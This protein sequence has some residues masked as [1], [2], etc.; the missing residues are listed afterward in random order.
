MTPLPPKLPERL[1][2]DAHVDTM[3]AYNICLRVES[4]LQQAVNN[5]ENIGN[6][7]IYIRILGYLIHFVPTDLGLRVVVAEILS[8]KSDRA[9]L[10]VGKMYFNHYIRACAF[11]NL[12]NILCDAI[13]SSCQQG[14]HTN[15][16]QSFIS[17]LI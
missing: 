15:T 17:S 2:N 16:V 9:L 4:S 12:F 7:I 6:D 11:P 5:N 1:Q 3:S 13:T 10:D 14:P 8:A